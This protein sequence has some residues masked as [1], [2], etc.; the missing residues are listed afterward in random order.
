MTRNQCLIEDFSIWMKG[1]LRN[2]TN[3]LTVMEHGSDF[4]FSHEFGLRL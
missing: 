4:D 1:G 3:E 2:T